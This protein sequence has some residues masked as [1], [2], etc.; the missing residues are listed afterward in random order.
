MCRHPGGTLPDKFNHPPDLRAFYNLMDRSEVTH[1]VLIASHAA[2]THRRMADLPVGQIVLHLHDATEL[3]FTS[4]TTLLDDLGQI[5]QGSRRGYIC[6][7]SLTVRR[8]G[9]DPGAVVANLT[10][11]RRCSGEGNDQGETRACGSRKPLVDPG[12]HR[13]RF[14]AGG[15]REH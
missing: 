1:A 13:V 5:G 15:D 10:S 3:D 8:Y 14:G 2:E 12:C 11:P 4:K 9:R 7:N 6:H